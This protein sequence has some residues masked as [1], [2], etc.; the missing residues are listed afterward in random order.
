M[1]KY[2][3]LKNYVIVA[4]EQLEDSDVVN[5]AM[6]VE[7]LIDIEDMVPTPSIGWVLN[8]NILQI[9]QN[10]TDREKFEIDLNYRKRTFGTELAQEAIDRVGARNKILNKTESQVSALLANLLNVKILMETGALGTS[11]S[12]CLQCKATYSEYADILD[13]V[14]EKINWFEKNFGL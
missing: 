4:I 14:I 3:I 8:G 5:R 9:P 11:R 6:E 7:M 1:R 12:M 13:F 10:L 2:A